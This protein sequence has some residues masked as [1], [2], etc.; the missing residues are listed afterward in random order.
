MVWGGSV[1]LCCGS[2]IKARTRNTNILFKGSL[3]QEY[4]RVLNCLVSGI[5]L[6][7]KHKY[8]D[9][10]NISALSCLDSVD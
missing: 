5:T 6:N 7:E 4:L 2:G 1:F 9:L 3:T 8:G 10:I